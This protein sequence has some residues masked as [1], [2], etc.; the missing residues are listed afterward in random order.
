MTTKSIVTQYMIN[1]RYETYKSSSFYLVGYA[2]ENNLLIYITAVDIYE[3]RGTNSL[4]NS[5]LFEDKQ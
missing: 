2:T 5:G 4:V 1:S 3:R